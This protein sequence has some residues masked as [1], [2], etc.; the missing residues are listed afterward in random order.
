MYFIS[1]LYK[2]MNQ[3]FFRSFQRS[4]YVL[5]F[6][7]ILFGNKNIFHLSGIW[8]KSVKRNAIPRERSG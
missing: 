2:I 4:K 7:F 3:N 1:L 6:I 8:N 5:C